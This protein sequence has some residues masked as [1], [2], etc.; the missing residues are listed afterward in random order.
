MTIEPNSDDVAALVELLACPDCAF[1]I[2][3]DSSVVYVIHSPTC[4]RLPA[5]ARDAGL[6]T[7]RIDNPQLLAFHFGKGSRD[8]ADP[9]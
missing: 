7:Y 8:L 3:G 1:A 4:P 2:K 9:R 5:E 6:C